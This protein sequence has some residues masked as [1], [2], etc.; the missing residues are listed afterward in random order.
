M[1]VIIRT[2]KA[3]SG[4]PILVANNLYL[5]SKYDPVKEGEKFAEAFLAETSTRKENL[6]IMGLGSG[7]HII[8]LQ[9]YYRKI[10]VFE[11]NQEIIS[12][13]RESIISANLSSLEIISSSADFNM[14]DYDIYWLNSEKRIFFDKFSEFE[15]AIKQSSQTKVADFSPVKILLVSPIY[16]GSM[17]TALYLKEALQNLSLVYNFTDNSMANE[18]FQKILSYKDLS[19]RNKQA[20]YLIKLLSEFIIKDAERIEA[21]LVIFMAQSPINKDLISV[22]REKGITSAFWFVEDYRR[23]FYWKEYANQFDAFFTI[24]KGDFFRELNRIQTPSFTYLPMAANPLIHRKLSLSQEEASH[25]GSDISFM[26]E[27]FSNRHLLFSQLLSYNLK[28]WGT[29]W[30]ENH[31]FANVLQNNGERVSIEDTVKIYNSAKIN[32][33]HHSSMNNELFET[34]GDFINPRTFEI[35]ACGGFQ[36]VD[37]RSLL[38]EIFIEDEEIVTFQSIE[39]LKN[40]IDY[41]LIHEEERR[42]I[43]ERGRKKV[44]EKHTYQHRIKQMLETIISGNDNF[45]KKIISQNEQNQAIF[46]A[47]N[48]K[49]LEA[50]L[51]EIPMNQKNSLT[52]M[53]ELIRNKKSDVKKHEGIIMTLETFLNN[54]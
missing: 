7:Y 41:Y 43:A 37:K 54:E 51:T 39:E 15:T 31:L 22:L 10:I 24:Q 19:W 53:A 36:L 46:E 38:S 52:F 17:T 3:H 4:L 27:G 34:D 33:N 50:F 21:N 26:G 48:D 9:K 42:A 28:I 32:I 18:I 11:P 14:K 30:N 20:D 12:F 6:L 23:F 49:E 8:P 47:I 35:M 13:F 45:R 1:Q 16:G 40:K 29:G 5:H 2:E 25:F 44:L